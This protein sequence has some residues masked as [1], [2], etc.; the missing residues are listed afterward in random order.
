MSDVEQPFLW[1]SASSSATSSAGMRMEMHD[2]LHLPFR[3]MTF[4]MYD[5]GSFPC[6]VFLGTFPRPGLPTTRKRRQRAQRIHR[7][8]RP[9]PTI[10]SIGQFRKLPFIAGA[11]FKDGWTIYLVEIAE[12]GPASRPHHVVP[13]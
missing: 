10:P 2:I 3:C 1:A 13:R 6:T 7:G 8:T 11:G 12:A 5:I 4:G 9:G